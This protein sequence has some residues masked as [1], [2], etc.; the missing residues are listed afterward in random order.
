MGDNH[1]INT[2]PIWIW[3]AVLT[4]AEIGVTYLPFGQML[5]ASFL[6]IFAVAKAVLVAIYFM[7]LKFE[8]RALHLIAISPFVLCILLLIFLFPDMG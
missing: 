5:M 1:Q 4:V 7:H 6:I 8:K 3:L 2:I